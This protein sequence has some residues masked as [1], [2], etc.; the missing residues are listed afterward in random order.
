MWS[1]RSRIGTL[2]PDHEPEG[3]PVEVRPALDQFVAPVASQ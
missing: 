3:N 2:S 1:W